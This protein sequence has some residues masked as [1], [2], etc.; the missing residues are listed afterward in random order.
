[1]LRFCRGVLIFGALAFGFSGSGQAQTLN[2]LGSAL[3]SSL[4]GM[5]PDVSSANA[6]NTGGLLS[7]CVQNSYLKGSTAKSLLSRLTGSGDVG[8]ASSS[9][10]SGTKGILETGNGDTFSL[11]TLKDKAKTRLCDAIL[12]HAKSF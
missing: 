9:Y 10:V 2:G 5:L 11:S 1:M 6:S 7:Y 8:T 4:K 12:E 3:G